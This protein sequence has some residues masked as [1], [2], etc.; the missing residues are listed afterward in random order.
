MQ[1]T[2]RHHRTAVLL[3]LG[4]LAVLGCV[5]QA[6]LAHGEAG[7]DGPDRSGVLPQPLSF[8]PCEQGL[9]AVYPCRNAH[10][11]SYLPLAALGGS[12]SGNDL[13]GWAEP[14]SGREFVLFGRSD[15]TAF[16]EVT[17]PRRPL[18]VG[19]LPTA[20]GSSFW[21]D[22]KVYGHYALVVS[23]APFHGL[24]VFDLNHLLA[25]TSPPQNFAADAWYTGFSNAHN[26][27]VNEETGFAYAV[28][29]NTCSGGL[30]AIDLSDPLAPRY[31]G[32]FAADGYTHDA[33]C[34]LY[35]GP[36]VQFVGREICFC[37][38][39][40]TLT[41]V[42][43]TD[44]A[45]PHM[46][47]RTDYVARGYTHQGWLTPDH[48]YFLLDDEFDETLLPSNTRTYLWDVADLT[49]PSVRG[50]FMNSTTAIDHNQYVR[51]WR[52]HWL[53]FQANYRAGLRVLELF[54][55][56]NA[57]LREIAFFDIYPADDLPSFNGA[58]SV[59][60]FLPSGTVAVSGIEQGL[61]LVQ[62]DEAAIGNNEATPSITAIASPTA[63][64]SPTPLRT[65]G[66]VLLTGTVRRAASDLG[67]PAVEVLSTNSHG[68]TIVST[69]SAGGFELSAEP[70]QSLRLEPRARGGVGAAITTA[71][72]VA[73]LR[74]LVRLELL[75]PAQHLAADTNGSGTLSVA[76]AV[77]IL[78]YLVG[79]DPQLLAA[80]RCDSDWW[81]FPAAH[82]GA[83]STP[84]SVS[85][86]SC[87]RGRLDLVVPNTGA[88]GLLF[89]ALPI[90]DA[91]A[92]W[93]PPGGTC[94]EERCPGGP[95]QSAV[96][97]GRPRRWSRA[98]I[99]VPLQASQD[100]QIAHFFLVRSG[101]EG[102]APFVRMRLARAWRQSVAAS[103]V[104]TDGMLRVA[105]AR[106]EALPVRAGEVIGWLLFAEAHRSRGLH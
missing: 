30:H 50:V 57:G 3:I 21:R 60:P 11:L 19:K 37:A 92:S 55:T 97:A 95:M 24:Q 39:E 71:D 27:V 51:E 70:E 93:G 13:W 35:R 105:A 101:R 100:G 67:V 43:M 83:A 40:D 2:Q 75:S 84:P 94:P 54:D 29:S 9:A 1:H 47:S 17:D 81:F 32:C 99:A 77:H 22:I 98:R 86:S 45:A 42:D 44:K 4:A 5:A 66:S 102:S 96:K 82:P 8:T 6:A 26:L 49:A 12:G 41:I 52:G 89:E 87:I 18:F 64:P 20:S 62:L 10:L 25:V 16:V 58:W 15:G 53:V 72:A 73:V 91:N 38:N 90:G 79:L 103:H 69:D 74:Y 23:E 59:Y 80:E 46:L 68:S 36:D 76:D 28:G 63:T 78:R 34:V 33:H 106:A 56:A 61:F 104:G 31:A 65:L 48:A 14:Q 7:A 88:S 85:D